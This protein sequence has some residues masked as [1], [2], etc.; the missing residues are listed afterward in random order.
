MTAV[1]TRRPRLWEGSGARWLFLP[2]ALLLAVGLVGPLCAVIVVGARENGPAGMVTEP[3]SSALFLRAAWRTLWMSAL[4]TACTWA[5]GLVFALALALAPRVL[6]RVLFGV[7]FLTFW[8][9]LLV[10]TY[11][12]V[13]T[14]QPSGALDSLAKA[15]HLSRDGLGLY[16]TMPGLIPA[17]VHIMLPYMVLPIYAGL[18]GIDPARLR[19][20]RSLGGGEL[21]TLRSIV[22]PAVRTGSAAGA[23]LVF[24]M[25]LGFYVTPA[26][27]GGP[28]QQLVATVIGTQFG[29]L[30]DL[31]G[32]AAMGVVLL[33]AA[34]GL[35]LLADRVFGIG[36]RWERL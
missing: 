6:G 35:Y 29:R 13:L 14:L 22:L 21:L 17:M 32:A 11:G 16:Q 33:V 20:A 7:L 26:F 1:A 5:A 2:P 31:G 4:V 34:L 3:F 12:W 8:I 18:R 19:A 23:V 24:V 25:C 30:Q 36:E 10:R 28:E 27:L 15:L 9:S